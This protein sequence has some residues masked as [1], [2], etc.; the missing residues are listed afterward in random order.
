MKTD[1]IVIGGGVIGLMS[2]YMLHQQGK[3]VT[4][5]DKGDITDNTSFGNAGLLSAFEKH[6]LATPGVVFK[7]MKMMLQGKSPMIFNPTLD[8]KVYRW[9]LR[10]MRSS[11]GER[12]KRTLALFEKYGEMSM[13]LYQEIM[14]DHDLDFDFHRDG[15][16]LVFTSDKSFQERIQSV[17]NDD[18][19]QI[20]SAKETRTYMPFVNNKISGSLLLKRNGHIDPALMMQ[21]MK[22]HLEASG[23][24]FILDEEIID[25]EFERDKLARVRSAHNSYEADS[26][27]LSTG[28]D[29]ALAKKAGTELIIT[30]AKGYSITFEM[31]EALKP[32]TCALFNDLFIACTPRKHDVR[33][34]SKLELAAKDPGV[35]Q[36]RIDSILTNLNAYTHD[37]EIK[38]PKLWAGFRPLPPNDMPLIGRDEHYD[39]LIYATGLGWLGI[40]FAPAIGKIIAD[41]ITQELPNKRSDDIL[42]FS[43]F[44]QG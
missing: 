33:L 39:N 40:T 22:E 42:L 13:D 44:Y 36:D 2:A 10:F 5:I 29:V 1:V 16:L 38:N 30:P 9:I 18:K 20:L 35:L 26:F 6:P 23:V 7:T 21:T 41:L 4:V 32:K 12:V 17:K 34:T 24:T 31:E 43:G 15:L 14:R 19:Y 28:A 27:V 3:S 25:F 8:P 37:F 11:S